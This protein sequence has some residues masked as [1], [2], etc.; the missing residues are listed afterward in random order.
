M[1]SCLNW[2]SGNLQLFKNRSKKTFCV[3]PMHMK[4]C[5]IVNLYTKGCTIQLLQLLRMK[6]QE[7]SGHTL[8]ILWI[9]IWQRGWN[10]WDLTV[11]CL[12]WW[13]KVQELQK[14]LC[15]LYYYLPCRPQT[16]IRI[17]GHATFWNATDSAVVDCTSDG[18]EHST[19]NMLLPF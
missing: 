15:H 4:H 5:I 7:M 10:M 11:L 16:F 17:L 3:L 12:I 2:W 13:C 9:T 1:Y 19:F 6:S 18:Q 14:G 8:T